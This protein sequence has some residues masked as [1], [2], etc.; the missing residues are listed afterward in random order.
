M[1]KIIRKSSSFVSCDDDSYEEI[2]AYNELSDIIEPQH[3]AE[4]DGELNT[5]TFNDIVDHEGPISPS[6]SKYKGSSY[7]VLVS[8]TDGSKTWDPLNIV[9]KDD[10]VTLANYAK[11]NDLLEIPGWKF[12]RRTARRATPLGTV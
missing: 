3:Q 5:W 10:M 7:N 6:S 2:I 12:L 4:A 11:E 9:V 8:W 1:L